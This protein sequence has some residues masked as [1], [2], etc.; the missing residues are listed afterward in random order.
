MMK[1][2]IVSSGK[3]ENLSVL[4]TLVSENNFIVCADGGLDHLRR[5]GLLPNLV[6]GDFDSISKEGLNFIKDNSIEL[7]KFPKMKDKTDTE[8]AIIYLMENGY[9]DITITGV[10][11]SRMDHT[12]ANVFLLKKLRKQGII[13]KIVDDNNTIYFEDRILKLKKIDGY[14]SIIP[15]NKEGASISLEG[16]LYQLDK[17]HI[18]FASTIGISNEIIEELGI[19]R[20]HSGEVLIFKSRD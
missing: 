3:I 11:G 16:F 12:I 13:A 9:K 17:K 6:L 2:L 18:P 14:I 1:G 5:I 20:I 7:L 4:E 15:L 10:T 19:I 8:L